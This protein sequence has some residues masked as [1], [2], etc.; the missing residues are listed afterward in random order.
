MKIQ[1]L[2]ELPGYEVGQIVTVEVDS[3]GNP[4][5]RYWRRRLKDSGRDECIKIMSD[6]DM[7]AREKEQKKQFDDV[8][9]RIDANKKKDK[10][11]D[12]AADSE[13]KSKGKTEPANAES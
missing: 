10:S 2:R 11:N 7:A 3:E 1:I 4:V 9:K 13:E 5:D 8:R 12:K 6:E